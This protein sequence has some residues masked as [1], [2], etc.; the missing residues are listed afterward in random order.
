MSQAIKLFSDWLSYLEGG[1]FPYFHSFLQY[2]ASAEY[3]AS[4]FD[5]I[6]LTYE[7]VR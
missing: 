3:V 5:S 1:E 4:L 6:H 2:E 7:P